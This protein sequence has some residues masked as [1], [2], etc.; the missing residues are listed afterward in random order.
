MTNLSVRCVAVAFVASSLIALGCSSEREDV[1]DVDVDVDTALQPK[2]INTAGSLGDGV[3]VSACPSVAQRNDRL[4]RATELAQ[5]LMNISCSNNSTCRANNAPWIVHPCLATAPSDT[6]TELDRAISFLQ[7]QMALGGCSWTSPF[8]RASK[9]GVSTLKR[10][11]T[12]PGG[13]T[14][15]DLGWYADQC[16]G[17][18]VSGFFFF[19]SVK[20]GTGSVF[21]IDP[22]DVYLD[23]TLPKTSGTPAAAHVAV[24]NA[25]SSIVRWSSSASARSDGTPRG[26]QPC[27]V[28]GMTIGSATQLRINEYG[29]TRNCE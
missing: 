7:L 27:S 4:Q 23:A 18:G 6:V 10:Q 28:G 8:T 2:M 16:W 15:V 26:G 17:A 13:T 21:E 24:T 12:C 9:C 1:T 5:W 14:D 20:N 22:E 11:L 25:A 29:D 3:A 19:S